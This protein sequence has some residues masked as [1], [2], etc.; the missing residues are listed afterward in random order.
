L[1]LEATMIPQPAQTKLA[2]SADA[3]VQPVLTDEDASVPAGVR[4][5][6]AAALR[7]AAEV[8]HQAILEMQPTDSRALLNL[9]YLAR[10]WIAPLGDPRPALGYFDA[11]AAAEPR[12][13]RP[14]LEMA[15]ELRTLSRLNE[16]EALYLD[17]LQDHPTLVRALAGLGHIARARGQPRLALRHYRAALAA[18]PTR[19]DLQLEAAAQLRKLS[20]FREAEQI[21]RAILREHPDHAAAQT[22]LVRVPQPKTSGLPPLERAWLKRDTFTRAAEWG[23]NLEALGVPAFDMSLLALAQDFAYGAS[24]E[25]KRDCILLHLDERTKLLP[26]VSDREEYERILMRE[27]QALRPGALLGFVPEQGEEGWRNNVVVAKSHREFVWHRETVSKMLG[28]SLQVYR[29]QIRELLKAGAHVEPIGPEN[30]DRVL[31]CNDRWYAAKAAKGKSTRYR[32]PTVWTF[33]NLSRLEPLG[34]RHLAV[35]L[36]DDVIGYGIGSHLSA[37]WAAYFYGQG[38][39]LNGVAPLIVHEHSKLYPDRQWINAGHAGRS[40]GLAA[41]KQK[42]TANAADKQMALGWIQA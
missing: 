4:L 31:A 39:H 32:A 14:K 34:V 10:Q 6:A 26:L 35:M 3:G 37:S 25:V 42:F 15:L 20:R 16:A 2:S 13:T 30:L 11:A 22:R 41:F 7:R 9:G 33:E 5:D 29:R 28:S 38:D 24:E 17:L 23:Q 19:T 21:Y 12:R 40:R 1:S 8:V 36:D 27:A 18:N